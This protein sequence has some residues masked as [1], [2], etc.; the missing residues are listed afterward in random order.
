LTQIKTVRP[1]CGILDGDMKQILC[2]LLATLALAA[3]AAEPPAPAIATAPVKVDG[4]TL[5]TVRGVSSLPANER[6]Q[7]IAQRIEQVA[8]DASVA[9]DALKVVEGQDRTDIVAG[10]TLIVAV[11]D[12]DAALEGLQQRQLLAKLY[13][14]R[15]A[16]AIVHY[17]HDREP[18]VRLRNAAYA[19]GALVALVAALTALAWLFRRLNAFLERRYKARIR[20]VGIKSFRV[21]HA[22]QLWAAVRG[23][24][25]ALEALAMLA[26]A[27]LALQFSLGLFPGTRELAGRLLGLVTDPLVSMGRGLLDFLPNLFFLAILLVVTRYLLKITRLFFAA[28]AN[29]SVK[30]QAFDAEWSWPTYRILRLLVIAFALVIAYPYIPGSDS[31]AFK[32]VSLF[33]GVIFSLGSTS[34]I[35]NV[36]AGYA[37]TYRRAFRVGDRIK[38]GDAVGDVTEMRL[39]VTHLRS[40]KNEEIVLPNSQ[41]IN[42]QVLNYSTLAKKEGL[43]LHTTVGI[44]YETP[45]R[46]VEALLRMAAERT[47]GLKREPAPFVLQRALGDF[48]VTY[49]LNAYCDDPARMMPL[50]TALHRNILDVFNEYGVQIMT[51]AYVADTPQPK[52]VAK[53][54]WFAAPAVQSKGNAP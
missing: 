53:D 6:A 4:R 24:L 5:F 39:Q 31:A 38:V 23:L 1:P 10:A 16:K 37:L 22:E 8:R 33:L 32:G 28:V 7:A 36:L 52:L 30:V 43:I 48:C 44:G 26:S 54:Q 19:L 35:A 34:I 47:E 46:Q 3:G 12:A 29:G 18:E 15:I 11:V 51:P 2:L 25:R 42:S 17:R 20:D 13:R 41:V 45:W 14:E 50:Y 9:P 21:V 49:E 27:Y 40:L